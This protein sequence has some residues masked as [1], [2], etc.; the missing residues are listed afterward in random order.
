MPE[1][2]SHSSC[3]KTNCEASRRCENTTTDFKH[4]Q[5]CCDEDHDPAAEAQ[6]WTKGN[7]DAEEAQAQFRDGRHPWC[8]RLAV[9]DHLGDGGLDLGGHGFEFDA[10]ATVYVAG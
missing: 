7:L 2:Y 3:I 5:D 10:Q 8:A 4:N 1:A 6:R 9:I